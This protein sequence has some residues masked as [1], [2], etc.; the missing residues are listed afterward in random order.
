M[1]IE[2]VLWYMFMFMV[3]WVMSENG[4]SFDSMVLVGIILAGLSILYTR[5]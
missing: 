3:G 5:G 4:Y 2:L 1:S